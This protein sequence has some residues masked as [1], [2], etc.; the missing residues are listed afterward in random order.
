MDIS[1]L[2]GL[3][4]GF[5]GIIL[6]NLLEGGHFSA[7][8]QV[9][10]GIIVFGG[11]FGAT[12][13]ANSIEDFKLGLRLLKESI[14]KE[15]PS[16]YEK[17]V[18]AIVSSA[19]VARSDSILALDEKVK[20]YPHPFMKKVFRF[21]VDGV[22]KETLVDVFETEIDNT[23]TQMLRGARVWE[24]AGGYA[25]T[26]G[27]IG[28]VLGLIHVMANLTDTSK[29]GQGIAVAFVATIYGV[30]SANLIF[31][32]IAQK[33]KGR[34]KQ[35]RRVKEMILDGAESIIGGFSPFIVEEKMRTYKTSSEI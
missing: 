28:A 7:L 8:V 30:G 14:R 17:I 32:P 6:G 3:G 10:A 26:I 18:R 13:L 16:S 31:L 11:T 27:I 25:P 22:D 12:I 35:H 5:G 19:Q 23:E 9:T 33:I 4:L 34:V 20:S 29:L 15:D 21:V 24:D 2:V 1:V